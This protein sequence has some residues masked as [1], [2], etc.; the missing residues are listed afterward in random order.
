MTRESERTIAVDFPSVFK[1]K[2]LDPQYIRE[3]VAAVSY[4]IVP[5]A[6]S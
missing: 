1:D 4:L 6:S 2:G 5:I 3:A